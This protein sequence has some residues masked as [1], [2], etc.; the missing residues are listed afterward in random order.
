MT[1]GYPR[2]SQGS[3][4]GVLAHRWSY[5]YHVGP[6]PDGLQ[7]DHLCR[8]RHCVN[9]QHLE[10]VTARENTLRGM[11]FVAHLAARTEC[12]NGHPLTGGNLRMEGTVRRCRACKREE[13][14]RR[15][16]RQKHGRPS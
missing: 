16:A 10:P 15:R 9:P 2:F 13:A 8:V 3:H 12:I 11:S 5:E 1:G 4:G 14:R 6:I 7:L